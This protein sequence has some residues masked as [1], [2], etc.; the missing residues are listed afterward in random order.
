[1]KK[2]NKPNE[3]RET[4][5]GTKNN[6]SC[7][8]GD[9]YVYPVPPTLSVRTL[10]YHPPLLPERTKDKKTKAQQRASHRW[11]SLR[12]HSGLLIDECLSA[13]HRTPHRWILLRSH[14]GLLID[15]CL[16]VRTTDF[17]SLLVTAPLTFYIPN[18]K[19]K[20]LH[21]LIVTQPP[22][23]PLQN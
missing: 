18:I 6:G 13:Q 10:K 19:K 16:S 8:K 15:E 11:K 14:N 21:Q 17:S 1:M 9:T 3:I 12:S 7:A 22:T 4:R 23:S 20:K 2:K 5:E